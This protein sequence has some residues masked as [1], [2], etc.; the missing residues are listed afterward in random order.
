MTGVT[1]AR[2]VMMPLAQRD[3]LT[4]TRWSA[5]CLVAFLLLAMLGLNPLGADAVNAQVSDGSIGNQLVAVALMMML[6]LTTWRREQIG[7]NL[8]LPASILLLLAYCLLSV[9]WSLVPD[10]AVRRLALAFITMWVLFRATTELGY[11]RTLWL[12][13]ITM[14]VLL[15]ANY[16]TVFFLDHGIH[17]FEFGAYT[18]LVGNWRGL[19]GHKNLAGPV[20]AF[21]V[22]L[23]LFDRR[24]ASRTLFN[25]IIAAALVFLYFT[26]SKSTMSGLMIAVAAGYAV[27]LRFFHSTQWLVQG[28]LS[29]LVL[30]PLAAVLFVDVVQRSIDPNAFSGRMQIWLVLLS[31]VQDHFWTGA[32]FGSV[33]HVGNVSPILALGEGWVSDL[34]AAGHNGYLDLLAEAGLPGLVLGVVALL[35]LPVRRLYAATMPVPCRS[36]LFA[37][38]VFCV[39]NNLAESQFIDGKTIDQLFLS[40]AIALIGLAPSPAQVGKFSGFLDRARHTLTLRT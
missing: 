11:A 39:W 4:R 24:G 33:W 6:L 35:M 32:G 8:A 10:I 21:T 12:L 19:L 31:Y 9:S 3:M 40:I 23:F 7:V 30:V 37:I 27:R 20:A 34:A 14:G 26:Q 28:L 38:I 2:H 1:Q 25:M 15:V 16:F 17:R 5:F 36:L 18:G 29:L 22:L 13:R